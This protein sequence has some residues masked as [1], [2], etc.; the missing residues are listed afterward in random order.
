MTDLSGVEDILDEGNIQPD[1]H[2]EDDALD[3]AI[4]PPAKLNIFHVTPKGDRLPDTARSHL[5]IRDVDYNPMRVMSEAFSDSNIFSGAVAS[6]A[7]D[8][9]IEYAQNEQ[10]GGNV[11]P[12]DISPFASRF[13]LAYANLTTPRAIAIRDRQIK[14]ELRSREII[15]SNG[16]W[17]VMGSIG[18]AA[19]D[20]LQIAVPFARLKTGIGFSQGVS[21]ALP[22][23]VLATFID[24]GILAAQHPTR[25]MNEAAQN[26]AMTTGIIGLVSGITGGFGKNY[27]GPLIQKYLDDMDEYDEGISG[28]PGIKPPPDDLGPNLDPDHVAPSFRSAGSGATNEGLAAKTPRQELEA[29]GLK[30]AYGFERLPDSP[31]KT[32]LGSGSLA[33]RE[34]T[35]ALVESPGLFQNKNFELVA[36]EPSVE[37]NIR[38]W[39]AKMVGALNDIEMQFGLMR[40]EK[41]GGGTA[42]QIL[43]MAKLSVK[44]TFGGA[45]D[46][47]MTFPQFREAVTDALRENEVHDNPFVVAAA[48]KVRALFDELRDEA[49]EQDF[50]TTGERTKLKVVQDEQ[51]VLRNQL[52]DMNKTIQQSQKDL[53]DLKNTPKYE[54]AAKKHKKLF[55]RS[56]VLKTK[57]RGLTKKADD[58]EQEI[59][60]IRKE[61]PVVFAGKGYVPR[62]M[63][64]DKIE[65]N[66]ESFRQVIGDYLRGQG[67]H[68]KD[69]DAAL[70]DMIER[71]RRDHNYKPI[72]EF[73]SG[74]AASAR[75][76]VL[77]LEDMFLR[78]FI[79]NDIDIILRHHVRTFSTDLE[80]VKRFGTVDLYD[81]IKAMKDEVIDKISNTK[82]SVKQENIRAELSRDLKLF[83][84][85]RDR[86]RG[87]YGLPD[88]PYRMLS[89]TYR[90]LKQWNY[91]TFLGGV[92]LS[93]LPDLARPIMTEGIMRTMK[94]TFAA[95]HVGKDVRALSAKET[96]VAG[97]ALDMKESTRALQM[98]DLGDVHGRQSGLERGLH[99]A[100]EAFSM[101]NLLNPWNTAIK[102]WAGMIIAAR[103]FES[104]DLF[105]KSSRDDF[106]PKKF[107]AGT[108]GTNGTFK[109]GSKTGLT[110]FHGSGGSRKVAVDNNVL[111]SAHYATP[112][113]ATA[114]LYGS[115]VKETN[116]F[117]ENPYVIR[118]DEDF[119]KLLD[120][121]DIPL[122]KYDNSEFGRIKLKQLLLDIKAK[123]ELIGFKG[124]K[125]Q[126]ILDQQIQADIKRV[127]KEISDFNQANSV[128]NVG[129][130]LNRK[131]K[132]DGYDGVIVDI[133]IDAKAMK[134]NQTRR[135]RDLKG[136][137]KREE[138]VVRTMLDR[139]EGST[140]GRVFGSDQ[141]IFLNGIPAGINITAKK[142]PHDF[143]KLARS[144]IDKPMAERLMKQ[145]HEHGDIAFRDGTFMRE[146]IEQAGYTGKRRSEF[147][148]EMIERARKEG[149]VFLPNTDEWADIQAIGRFRAALAQDV[150]RTIVTP[151]AADRPLFMST[152]LGSVIFQFKGFGVSSAQRVLV[153]ALQEKQAYNMHGLI[154][155]VGM[156]MMVNQLKRDIS[157]YDFAEDNLAQAVLGGIDRSGLLGYF[158][159]LDSIISAA[160]NNT[161]GLHASLDPN[162]QVNTRG[163]VSALGGPSASKVLDMWRFVTD[164]MGGQYDRGTAEATK[165]L[166]PLQ[167][168]FLVANGFSEIAKSFPSSP[169]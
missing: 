87:T 27:N 45:P 80:L 98:A 134:A 23:T 70:L 13:P 46:G 73:E 153:S 102:E 68:G 130:Q 4:D 101:I 121:Y 160:S 135:P 20:P 31:Y 75:A 168:H 156:G 49:V 124:K 167:T 65:A 128:K 76:R 148:Q 159:D 106:F 67:L 136:G 139:Y 64:I 5:P 110:V 113:R 144:G 54:A 82:N 89:R 42:G 59:D 35:G 51:D 114:K 94:P 48:K 3:A 21:R 77:D 119:Q 141:A 12:F 47:K 43:G 129:E 100:G 151:G 105:A 118:N 91:L 133:G 140:V 39:K 15:S 154:M 95:L 96:N 79:E 166:I 90:V 143:V 53:A 137:E 97:T 145:F 14:A 146:M 25:T 131:L 123:R 162:K 117:M 86:L 83:M 26:I 36:S 111:G 63:R 127:F 52:D 169:N 149:A 6:W 108:W 10:T 38:P 92:V 16:F 60:A 61:G 24:E 107:S 158:S 103:I 125:G 161:A 1:Y 109:T 138:W 56:M 69:L 19:I 163:I 112:E 122:G 99:K 126:S 8:R 78:D 2:P 88:D 62:M 37:T 120:K 22:P 17:A 152:E 104:S 116:T 74:L 164:V 11:D 66:M 93:A 71:I 165:R 41:L 85:L 81:Q 147:I 57:M 32:L 40:G 7:Y 155:M 44:D 9:A 157:G 28:S 84:A 30:G 132:A 18:G 34:N 72:N 142:I 55:A 50:F 58:L 33:T 150:D 115:N 29:E